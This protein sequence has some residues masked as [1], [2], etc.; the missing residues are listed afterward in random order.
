MSQNEIVSKIE[1]LKEWE[2]LIEE[3]QTLP[4][5]SDKKALIVNDVF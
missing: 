3:A 1:Q 4:F 2:A 5:L